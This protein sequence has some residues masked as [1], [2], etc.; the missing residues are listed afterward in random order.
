[1]RDVAGPRL[2]KYRQRLATCQQPVVYVRA[3]ES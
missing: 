3:R 2:I 1:M